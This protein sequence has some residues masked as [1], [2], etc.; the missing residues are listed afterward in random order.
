MAETIEITGNQESTNNAKWNP[1]VGTEVLKLI[2]L[3]GF[4]NPNNQ[5][6]DA[7]NQIIDE[8]HK[9]LEMC[10]N[11]D[12][13]NVIETGLVLGYVQSGKTLSFT[14]LTAMARDNNYQIVIIIAGTSTPL[15]EQSYKRMLK[16]LRIEERRDRKWKIIKN[17]E[18]PNHLNSIQQSLEKWQDPTLPREKC[19]TVLIT[20]MKQTHRLQ[21]LINV[22][23]NLN[24]TNVPTLIIDDES[25]QASLNTRARAN[26]RS[27]ENVNEGDASTIYRRINSLREVFPHHTLLQYTATPQAN[28]FINIWD[29]LSPNFIKLLT[30]GSGYTGGSTFFIDNTELVKEIPTD[31]IP[32]N[33]NQVSQIPNSLLSALRI[34]FL[35]VVVGRIKDD[36]FNRTMLIH[37]SRLTA[38]HTD[39]YNWINDVIGSWTRLLES[40]DDEEKE[41][42]YASYRDAYDNLNLTV[43]DLP[44]FEELI[45]DHQLLHAIKYTRSMLVNASRGK[46]PHIPWREEYS[47]ILVG[48]QAMDRGFTVEG[49]TVTYMPRS[50]ATGQIDTTLQRARF[51]GYKGDYIGFCRVWLDSQNITAFQEIIEHEEDVRRRLTEYAES[52]RH[53]N[54][55]ERQVV[56]HRMLRLTR[57]NII[58]DDL[59]R[60]Y[61]GAEWFYIKAPHDTD[62][63]IEG[64]KT[65]ISEFTSRNIHEFQTNDG[66]E[67]RTPNQ[68]H[69]FAEL[70][71]DSTLEHLL[72]RL[73]FTK[74]SDSQTF[75]SLQGVLTAYSNENPGENCLVY[76]MS[77]EK[78]GDEIIQPIRKRRLKANDEVQQYFQGPNPARQGFARG[79][80][81]AGD[82]SVKD[83]ERLTIQIHRLELTDENNNPITDPDGQIVYQDVPSITIWI[84][85]S[86]GKDIVR[87][88]AN[89]L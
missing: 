55:W 44:R 36:Q 27:G 29:R 60:D 39:Y 61:L 42:L 83:T 19:S 67:N 5:I 89:S 88:P 35:G 65:V 57:P 50:L 81:Y 17:P 63:Y 11:P 79:E 68:K 41:H 78:V 84:P 18:N 75:S 49:L 87:Q 26:A 34:F 74:E 8:T 21:N 66:H 20:V 70:P 85:E 71:I 64:N 1:F 14:T 59:D 23:R 62:K 15:S 24:L 80:I 4:T 56:K 77:S 37:P 31:E 45:E 76:V 9:I 16:D 32:T 72:N 46:T 28:L 43:Q 22:M 7:G 2:E 54:D 69:L 6:D 40:S 52:N 12:E 51:F 82:R 33:Q 10:G 48:G 25:D 73:K 13:S 38:D 47:W 53:L 3:K 86:I 30:P 58:F